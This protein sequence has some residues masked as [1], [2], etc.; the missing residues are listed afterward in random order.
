[1]ENDTAY[2]FKYGIDIAKDVFQLFRVDQESGEVQNFKLKRKDLIAEFINRGKCLI[3]MEACGSSQYWARELQ[4]L[5]H[6]VRLMDPK[7]VKPF[8]SGYKSDRADAQGI[9]TAL[10]NNVR[11]VAVKN[12]AEVRLKALVIQGGEIPP[13]V[14]PNQQPVLSLGVEAVRSDLSVDKGVCEPQC[15]SVKPISPVNYVMR[16]SRLFSESQTASSR[17]F[18]SGL[19]GLRR[20]RWAWRAYEG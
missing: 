13:P 14:K 10:I 15:E 2:A 5:G 8:V 7:A 11:E 16:R 4:K 17:P 19:L 6:T 3:G 12:D 9:Y 18:W 20:G 1:M